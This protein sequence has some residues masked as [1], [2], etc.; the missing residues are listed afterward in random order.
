MDYA[1]S[2]LEKQNKFLGKWTQFFQAD[3]CESFKPLEYTDKIPSPLE[4]MPEAHWNEEEKRHFFYL[5][6]QFNC[7]AL[8]LFEQCLMYA[9][10]KLGTS[11][12]NA[13][14]KEAILH[15]AREEF[16]HTK[17]FR[18]YLRR[19]QVY[20]F[21]QRSLVVHRCHRLKNLFAWL[22]KQDP[23]AIVIPG[24]KSETYS[25]FYSKLFERQFG[26]DGNTFTKLNV[27]HSE[28]EVA[29]VQFDYQFADSVIA[30]R[31]LPQQFKFILFTFLTIL[32][33]QFIVI[34]GFSQALKELRPHSS[35]WFR[36]KTMRRIFRWVLW[37]FP[38]YMQTRRSLQATYSQ[39]KHFMYR[40][41]RLGSL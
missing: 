12:P 7:E 15:F 35:F 22:L 8:I 36:L 31:S 25:L 24:A 34:L 30:K 23:M 3:L 39:R 10:R 5:F 16:I 4:A 17:A 29:H 13:L 26:R 2:Y 28:D 6:A 11:L 32:V 18:H 27:L 19:E 1:A 40:F 14:E 37:N 33:I 9:S 21:P 20:Q 38:P 41:F